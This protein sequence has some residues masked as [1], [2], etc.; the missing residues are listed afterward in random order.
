VSGNG[1]DGIWSVT[2]VVDSCLAASGTFRPGVFAEDRIRRVD[3]ELPGLTVVAA[4]RRTPEFDPRGLDEQGRVQ[5]QFTE[6]VNGISEES[7]PVRDL[8]TRQPV[9][10][11]WTCYGDGG[12]T[13][14]LTGRVDGVAFAPVTPL[15]SGA[16]YEVLVNPSGS[17]GVTDLA[18][19]PAHR[20]GTYVPVP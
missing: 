12:E 14:C 6:P 20:S 8:A 2:A 16:Q 1:H 7:M 4:D 11:T 9:P 15:P 18:G 13:S 19:N 17:L 3:R 5:V 10:G